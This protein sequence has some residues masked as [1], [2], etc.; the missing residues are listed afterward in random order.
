MKVGFCTVNYSELP[1]REVV[2]LVAR[3]GYEAVEIPAYTG[4]G[5]M[6]VDEMLRNGNAKKLKKADQRC[7]PDPFGYFEPCGFPPG[8]WSAWERPGWNLPRNA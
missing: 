7:R 6:D 1:L 5:Q 8:A 2:E 4:N 3:K